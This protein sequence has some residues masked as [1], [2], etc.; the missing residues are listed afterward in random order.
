MY[1]NSGNNEIEDEGALQ[2]AIKLR[3]LNDLS[4]GSRLKDSE[5]NKLSSECKLRIKE[6]MPAAKLEM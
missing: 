3:S 2:L 1:S 6:L 4:I 5:K